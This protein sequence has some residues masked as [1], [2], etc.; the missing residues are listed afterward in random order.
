M[1]VKSPA[2][3]PLLELFDE[4]VQYLAVGIADQLGRREHLGLRLE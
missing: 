2:S 4:R 1:S 3:R